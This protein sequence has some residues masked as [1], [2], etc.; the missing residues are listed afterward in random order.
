MRARTLKRKHYRVV[1]GACDTVQQ[2]AAEA[3]KSA[4]SWSDPFANSA[5]PAAVVQTKTEHIVIN[6]IGPVEAEEE[7]RSFLSFTS[8]SSLL[9]ACTFLGTNETNRPF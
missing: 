1:A 9:W 6:E 5:V 4:S 2:H 8:I 3:S 7:D